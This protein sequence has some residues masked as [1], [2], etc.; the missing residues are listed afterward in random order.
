MLINNKDPYCKLVENPIF[1]DETE[2]N[3]KL[4]E[5]LYYHLNS[6][7]SQQLDREKLVIILE[8]ILQNKNIV[9]YLYD[10]YQFTD[11]N[12]DKINLFKK[13]YDDLVVN[14]KKNFENLNLVNDFV[15]S[16]IHLMYH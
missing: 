9:K 12:H 10:N 14:K 7:E 5:N 13:I 6:M 1:I 3:I 11:T 8:E 2:E 15:L 4:V 16:W